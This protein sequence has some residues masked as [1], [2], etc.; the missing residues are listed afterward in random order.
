MSGSNE[1][2]CLGDNYSVEDF[3]IDQYFISNKFLN[4]L[5][6]VLLRRAGTIRDLCGR[7]ETMA[8]SK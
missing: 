3:C 8:E 7:L 6:Y 1:I 2:T 5:K 4:I